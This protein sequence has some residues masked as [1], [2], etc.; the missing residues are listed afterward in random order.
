MPW[1]RLERSLV[2]LPTKLG[3]TAEPPPL[4]GQDSPQVLLPMEFALK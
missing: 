4:L 3:L 2:L 1:Q